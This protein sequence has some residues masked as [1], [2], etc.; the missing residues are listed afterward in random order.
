VSVSAGGSGQG[1]GASAG[2]DLP[3]GGSQ[4]VGVTV[5]T[6]GSPP[7]VTLPKLPKL[8]GLP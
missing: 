4:D 1:A 3:G 7:S 8:P 6:D 5:P 2:V